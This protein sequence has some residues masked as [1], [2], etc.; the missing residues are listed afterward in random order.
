MSA[1]SINVHTFTI[2]GNILAYTGLQTPKAKKTTLHN[3]A[4]SMVEE[5]EQ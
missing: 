3:N 1:G 2:K 5:R 4:K